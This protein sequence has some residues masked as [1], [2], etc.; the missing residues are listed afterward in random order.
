MRHVR[1]FGVV[2]AAVRARTLISGVVPCKPR[3]LGWAAGSSK[4]EAPRS[5]GVTFRGLS[6]PSLCSPALTGSDLRVRPQWGAVITRPPSG[7]CPL[8]TLP[9]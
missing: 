2:A 5:E 7:L 8:P 6:L 4:E 9:Q 1:D 3:L